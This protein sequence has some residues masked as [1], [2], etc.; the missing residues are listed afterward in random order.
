MGFRRHR[1][2]VSFEGELK[3]LLGIRR[4]RQSEHEPLLIGTLARGIPIGAEARRK[5]IDMIATWLCPSMMSLCR[6][7][8]IEGCPSV[9]WLLLRSYA[10]GEV[11]TDGLKEKAITYQILYERKEDCLPRQSFLLAAISLSLEAALAENGSDVRL[12]LA[13]AIIFIAYVKAGL[14]GQEGAM[15][16]G[17][18]KFLLDEVAPSLNAAA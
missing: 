4:W 5:I 8:C 13:T 7:D 18:R 17:M 3:R 14:A 1:T 11:W 15:N 16:D 6:P 10:A 12:Y 2:E 9:A